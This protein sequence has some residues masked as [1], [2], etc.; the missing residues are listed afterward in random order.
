MNMKKTIIIIVLLLA[1]PSLCLAG[2][3]QE[4]QKACI[5]KKNVSSCSATKLGYDG[6][7]SGKDGIGTAVKGGMDCHLWTASVGAGCTGNLGTGYLEHASTS[8]TANYK[9]CVYL[10]DGDNSPD[11]GDTKV[12]CSAATGNTN[13]AGWRS[14]AFSS[15][16][17]TNGSVYFICSMVDD[18]SSS[19]EGAVYYDSDTLDNRFREDGTGCDSF[20]TE[21]ATLNCTWNTVTANRRY[22]Y[23]IEVN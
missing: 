8:Y 16:T 17:V 7:S 6:T 4:K 12:A 19:A 18:N 2:A 21:P 10:D 11:S 5:A 9:L 20:D 1:L 15:G 3:L 14:V 13:T 22:H 23:Y